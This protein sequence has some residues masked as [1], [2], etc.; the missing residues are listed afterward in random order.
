MLMIAVPAVA[1][2]LLIL[3]LGVAGGNVRP[4]RPEP[5]LA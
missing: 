3:L 2:A 4:A 5:K 1:V